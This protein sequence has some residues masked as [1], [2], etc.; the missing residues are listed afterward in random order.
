[1]LLT[2]RRSVATDHAVEQVECTQSDGLV[3]VIKTLQDEIFVS[4]NTLG[5]SL[6]DLGHCHQAQILHYTDTQ[7][8]RQTDR[9]QTKTSM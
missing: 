4:L 5:M 8:L 6:E 9:R 2:H 3:L 7:A 1:M